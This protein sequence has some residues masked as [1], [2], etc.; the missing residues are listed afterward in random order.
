LEMIASARGKGVD[1]LVFPE[2]CVPGYLIGDMWERPAFLRECETWNQR[3][4]AATDA[5]D[6]AGAVAA[7]GAR[8][9]AAVFGTVIPDWKAKG[10]DGRPRK[11]NGYIAAMNGRAIRHP[12]LGR[13]YGIKTLLP[14]YREFDEPRHFHDARKLAMELDKPLEDLLEPVPIPLNG[15]LCRA[16]IILCEDAWEEDYAQKPL[17]ILGLK[18][19]DFM[20]NLSCSP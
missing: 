4:V 17:E 16:G 20:L 6:A 2:M 5:V 7:G 13:D 9:M 10:E 15:K 18:S 11:Y 3:I 8:P 1:L 12:G 19:C 14:N